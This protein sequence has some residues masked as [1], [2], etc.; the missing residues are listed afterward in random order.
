MQNA[1]AQDDIDEAGWASDGPAEGSASI[2]VAIRLRAPLADLPGLGPALAKLVGKACG[3]DRVVDLLLHLPDRYIQR[4]PV[5][6]PSEAPGDIEVILP[7]VVESLRDARSGAGRPYVEIRAEAGGEPLVARLMNT[8]L[9]WVQRA[10]PPGATRWFAGPVRPEGERWSMLSPLV[11]ATEPPSIEPVWPLTATLSNTRMRRSVEAALARLPPLPEWH[12]ASLMRQ[13]GWPGFAEALRALQAPDSLPG[14]AP[15]HR[16][17]YDELLAGQVA[18]ALVRGAARQKPGRSLTGDG[19]LRALALTAFGHTPTPAQ[20]HALAEIDADLATPHR[21]LRL[22]Q[23]DVGSGKTLVALMAMLR[24]VEAGAQAALMAPTELLARQ[25]LRTLEPLCAAAGVPIA[26]LAG[27][28]KGSARKRVLAGLADG[29]LPLVVGTHALFQ[30]AVEFSDLALAVVDEQHRFG[31]A[32]RLMLAEKGAA[33]DLLVMTATPIPRTLL[34]T[35]WGEM[36]VSRLAGKPAGRQPITTTLHGLSR[37]DSVVEAVGR[38]LAEGARVYW[39][40]PHVAESE[41]LDLAAAETR[42]LTLRERF[43][44]AVGLAHGQ[45]PSDQREQALS[46]F[47][48]GVTQLL[49]A[50]T[51]IEVGVDVPEA[52]VMVIEHADRFGLAQLHQLRGRVGRGAARSFCML[53]FEEGLSE[54]ARERLGILRDTEDGFVI[55]DADFRLRGAGDALGT[56][57]SGLPGFRLADPATQERLVH[58]AHQDAALLLNRDPGLDATPRGKAIPALLTLFDR[59]AAIG[60]LRAG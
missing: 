52:S 51:V 30:D 22:L 6:R 32:Q 48:A 43:G 56:R 47:R 49:V 13:E 59:D 26:L 24:A 44:D 23:G 7:A 42:A 34:L 19:R 18:I 21:M 17:A 35:Q 11:S 15:R 46:D 57:Q 10:T 36:A 54:T 50:T 37:L 4:V 2:T 40:C 33:A 53:L 29:S 9:A 41:V 55:A 3:G 1:E 60:T 39:V 12:D 31:V 16:L 27:T 38:K 25:H 8:K 14:D 28:V 20:T 5:A 45:M 58:M